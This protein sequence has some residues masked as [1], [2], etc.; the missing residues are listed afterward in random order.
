MDYE[1]KSRLLDECRIGLKCKIRQD[2]ES[3]FN[4]LFV[5][6]V[7]IYTSMSTCCKFSSTKS[8]I[9][10]K[11]KIYIAEN[12]TKTDHAGELNLC[13]PQNILIKKKIK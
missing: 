12:T 3:E 5:F 6:T 4:C 2:K 11:R 1:K 13:S 7:Q 9:C 10:Y 8:N